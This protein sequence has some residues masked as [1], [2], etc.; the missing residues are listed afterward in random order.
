MCVH[1]LDRYV[2]RRCYLC[3]YVIIVSTDWN[4]LDFDVSN[5]KCWIC[6]FLCSR[7]FTVLFQW[8]I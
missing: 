7:F 6:T 5:K 8:S 4:M 3:E 2:Y 1:V